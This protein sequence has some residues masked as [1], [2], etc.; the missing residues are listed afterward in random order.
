MANCTSPATT[1]S[2]QQRE[3]LFI[4]ASSCWKIQPSLTHLYL[5]KFAPPGLCI[6]FELLDLFI[7]GNLKPLRLHRFC[8]SLRNWSDIIT[9]L[10]STTIENRLCQNSFIETF[11]RCHGIHSRWNVCKH[12]VVS[13][14]L[15]PYK[16]W[17]MSSNKDTMKIM[18]VCALRLFSP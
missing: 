10:S 4:S 15:M 2:V 16:W 5:T 9:L 7:I 11:R 1:A 3:R 17:Y 8:C 18:C 12:V 13:R 6:D 14:H